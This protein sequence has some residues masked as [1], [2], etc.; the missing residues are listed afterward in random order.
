MEISSGF[1]LGGATWPAKRIDYSESGRSM[2]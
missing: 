1:A 2:R